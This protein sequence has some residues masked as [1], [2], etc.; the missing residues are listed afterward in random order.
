MISRDI[1]FDEIK[2]V[3]QCAT[4]YTNMSISYTS[5]NFVSVVLEGAESAPV[6]AQMEDNVRRTTKQRG[7]PIGHQDYELFQDNEINDDG[8]FVHFTL[9]AEFEPVKME[10]ALSDPKWICDMKE[11]LESIKKNKNWDLVDLPKRNKLIGIR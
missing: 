3:K 1:I 8:D 6:E 11:E 9:M 7:M 5:E 2:E 10:E 4:N